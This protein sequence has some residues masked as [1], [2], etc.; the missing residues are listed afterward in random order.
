MSIPSFYT[1][2][3]FKEK[4]LGDTMEFVDIGEILDG[5]HTDKKV[6]IRGWVHRERKQKKVSFL[7]QYGQNHSFPWN[8]KV[9]INGTIYSG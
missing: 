8:L 2:K 4:I 1:E 3:H 6:A 9:E 5:K 7:L